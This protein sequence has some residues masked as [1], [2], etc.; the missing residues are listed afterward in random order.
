MNNAGKRRLLASRIRWDVASVVRIGRRFFV[1]PDIRR[2]GGNRLKDRGLTRQVVRIGPD[3]GI[4]LNR[5]CR[6][7][8]LCE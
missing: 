3:A 7:Y 2:R 1:P 8:G 5:G 6:F 4:G